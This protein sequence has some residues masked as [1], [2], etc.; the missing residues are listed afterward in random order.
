[1]RIVFGNDIRDK[2]KLSMVVIIP[3][4]KIRNVKLTGD[5]IGIMIDEME[6]IPY[7]T[8][9]YFNYDKIIKKLRDSLEVEN[10][11]KKDK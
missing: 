1:M 7:S 9:I 5:E 2:R 10:E 4:N 11:T 8:Y 3:D 6:R